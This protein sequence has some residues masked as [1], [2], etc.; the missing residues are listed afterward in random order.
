MAHAV[1]SRAAA[2]HS[3]SLERSCAVEETPDG[4]EEPPDHHTQVP[5]HLTR[6]SFQLVEPLLAAVVVLGLVDDRRQLL[7]LTRRASAVPFGARRDGHNALAEQC[8]Q[9]GRKLYRHGRDELGVG[10]VVVE[11]GRDNDDVGKRRDKVLPASAP[12]R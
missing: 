7:A 12:P 2:C 9:V 5:L 6:A 10:G 8:G 1:L 4:V 3:G 11:V